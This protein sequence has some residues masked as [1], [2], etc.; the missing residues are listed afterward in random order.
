MFKTEDTSKSFF[1]FFTEITIISQL[2]G[3]ILEAALPSGFLASHFGVL[4]HLV[5]LGDGRTPLEIARAFQVPKATMTHTLSGLVKGGLI[6]MVP[7]PADGR[8]KCVML[9]TEGRRVRDAAI[10]RLEPEFSRMAEH[11][12]PETISRVLPLL[13]EM[14]AY[15]DSQRGF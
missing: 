10:A 13:A 14:R 1:S 2:S 3:K 15:L 11:F 6:S 9:T 5:R 4:N 12:P 8:S 7:N